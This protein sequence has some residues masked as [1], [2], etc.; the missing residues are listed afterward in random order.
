MEEIELS[1][2]PRSQN[3][4]DLVRAQLDEFEKQAR[5]RVKLRSV[6]WSRPELTRFA[7]YKQGPDV[8]EVGATWVD[9]YAAMNALRPFTRAEMMSIGKPQEFLAASWQAGHLPGDEQ[10]WAV[11]WLA[12]PY[13]IH[14]RK[15]ILRQ[16]GI[17]ETTAFQTHAQ[18]AKTI[19]LLRQN[20]VRMP[21]GAPIRSTRPGDNPFCI[22]HSLCSWVWA[23]GTDFC[24][25]DGRRVWFTKPEFLAALHDYFE[26]FRSVQPEDLPELAKIGPIEAFR[27]G[28][29]A[30]TF[31]TMTVLSPWN[32]VP[33]EVRQNWGVAS[34]PQVG[35]VGGTNLVVWDY[36]RHTREAVD[37]V[38]FL[39]K[40][41]SL[42][43]LAKPLYTL[44]PR[45]S[46]MAEPDFQDDP[47]WKEVIHAAQNGRSSPSVKL[48]GLIE[49]KL[50]NSLHLIAEAV[51]TDPALDLD[52]AIRKQLEPLTRMLGLTLA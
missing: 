25:P 20:G 26:L 40:G 3:S 31:G 15:D 34:F 47:L 14:Y 6:L 5:V 52:T 35:M 7:I 1:F 16:A 11:P 21:F 19:E 27:Q 8:S 36:T 37:L 24:S 10:V 17:D 4:G 45:L 2:L 48:W 23:R 41:S 12:E 39:T 49:E 32:E 33:Q 42:L 29:V 22:M 46:V 18:I 43:H 30:I 44:P 51:T 28:R 50:L 38:R 9:D 13:I